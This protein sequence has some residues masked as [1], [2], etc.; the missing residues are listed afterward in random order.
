MI[1]STYIFSTYTHKVYA[2][3]EHK[4]AH[5]IDKQAILSNYNINDVS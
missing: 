3:K 5:I 1:L 2:F 4:N